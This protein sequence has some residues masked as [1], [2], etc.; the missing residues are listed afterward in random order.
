MIKYF[1]ALLVAVVGLAYMSSCSDPIT[2]IKNNVPPNTYL[3][4]FSMPG[5]TVAPGKTVKKISWWGDSPAGFVVGFRISFDSLNWGYT[6]SN[7]STFYL[8]INGQDSLFRIWVAAVDDRGNVDPTPASNLYPIVNSNPT[9]VFDPS[10]TV[11]DTV[12]PVVTLKWIGSDP[13]GDNTIV[14]YWYSINDTLHFRPISG[15]LSTM[16]LT[17]D[18]GLAAGNTCVYMKAQDNAHAYSGIVRIPADSSKFFRVRN[19]T[20]R[21][22]LIKDM[23]LSEFSMAESYL[24]QVM[25]TVHYDVFDIRSNN[26]ALIPKIINPM[27]IETLK[28]Y[29]IVMWLADHNGGQNPPDDPNLNLAQNS[30]PYFINTGGKVF[31]SSGFPNVSIIQGSLFNFAPIDSVKTSCFVQLLNLNDSVYCLNDNSIPKLRTSFYISGTKGIYPSPGVKTIYQLL[32]RTHCDND[33]LTIGIKSP[34]N[35]PNLVFLLMPVFLLNADV[36]ASKTFM[37]QTLINDFGYGTSYRKT[38]RNFR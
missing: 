37:R 6:T 32:P 26:G 5:D 17:K 22:L 11:P 35:N 30:L 13:D 16:T 24:G 27:F 38:G 7:D 10:I 19:V 33:T 31:W 29:D 9:M 3:S 8:S 25:D 18:S 14:R 28:L 12:F 1:T 23:P 15:S 34:V 4:V 36:N 2:G 20:S 21:I